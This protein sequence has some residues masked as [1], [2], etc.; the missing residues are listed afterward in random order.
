MQ[1]ENS[2]AY[3]AQVQS[4]REEGLQVFFRGLGTTLGRAFVVNGV[5][6]AAYELS[7]S[8]LP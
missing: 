2:C 5:I 1:S 6:F 3:A 8:L 7:I 4:Y